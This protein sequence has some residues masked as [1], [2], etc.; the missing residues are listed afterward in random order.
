MT[1]A[2]LPAASAAFVARRF[3][4]RIADL[5]SKTMLANRELFARCDIAI[6]STWGPYGIERCITG[7]A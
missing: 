5:P 7:Q 2:Q 6:A 4:E 1:P 3:S